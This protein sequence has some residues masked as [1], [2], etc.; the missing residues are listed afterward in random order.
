MGSQV[1]L[2]WSC[3]GGMAETEVGVGQGVLLSNLQVEPWCD[4][5]DK[6]GTDQGV[7]GCSMQVTPW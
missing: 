2:P 1:V 4:F 3:P 6:V 5:G 7:P